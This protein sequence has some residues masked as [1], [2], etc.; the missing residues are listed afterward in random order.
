MDQVNKSTTPEYDIVVVGPYYCDLIYTGLSEMP[1]L[2]ADINS[3]HFDMVPGGAYYIVRVLH[4]L[5]LK[6]GWFCDFGNDFFSRFIIEQAQADGLDQSLF[7]HFDRPKRVVSSSFSFEHD[8]GFVSFED[9]P[10]QLPEYRDLEPMNFRSIL[11]SGVND[12]RLVPTIE[13]LG[14]QRKP[15]IFMDCQH[16]E[17]TLH[18]PGITE[19]LRKVDVF[20]PNECEALFFTGET[21]IQRALDVL[22]DVVPLVV[23]KLGGR[24]SLARRGSQTWEV[25]GIQV[26]V[27]DTTGAGDSYNAGFFYAYLK[28]NTIETCLRYGN[29]VGGLSVTAAGPLQCPDMNLIHEMVQDYE[30]FQ[31]K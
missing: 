29:V 24:G 18:S 22:A 16:T 19:A 7:R 3:Q 2:S 11:I 27:V 9:E 30:R 23:L 17:L 5:G 20:A 10:Y 4:R 8:R 13:K 12:W 26:E 6:T 31:K 14:D 28:G 21:D 15:I 1:R 25:P